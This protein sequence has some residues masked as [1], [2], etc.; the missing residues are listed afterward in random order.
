MNA[1]KKKHG[2]DLIDL[3][4]V[5]SPRP[6]FVVCYGGGS[7]FRKERKTSPLFRVQHGRQ[8]LIS[9]ALCV[10][11]YFGRKCK[12]CPNSK[13]TIAFTARKPDGS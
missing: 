6:G 2:T 11:Q 4:K 9:R 13:A 5:T 8:R 3:T 10:V 12:M 1:K 7:P